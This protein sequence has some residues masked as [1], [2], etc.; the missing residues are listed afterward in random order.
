[1]KRSK[2]LLEDTA[3]AP[4]RGYRAAS[5]SISSRTPWAF[6]ILAQEGY[7]YSSSVYPIRQD[8]YGMPDAPRF[9]YYPDQSLPILEVPITTVEVVGRKWPCGG[10]GY[11][12]LLPY[13][14]SRS[15]MRR[16]NRVDR[17]PCVFYFHPWEIDPEQPRIPGISVKSR[18]R[19][20]MNLR[21]MEGRLRAALTDFNWDRMDRIFLAERSRAKDTAF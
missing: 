13:A 11:F 17:Q 6:E 20:Y 8:L 19:H 4:V 15:A 18:M 3:G 5:F 7:E 21:R 16:V 2:Q 10:G 1:M 12:R 9:A 14:I